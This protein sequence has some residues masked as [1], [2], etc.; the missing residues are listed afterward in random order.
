MTL[1][2]RRARLAKQKGEFL[3]TSREPA[4]KAAAKKAKTLPAKQAA[5]AAAK[6]VAKPVADEVVQPAAKNAAKKAAKRGSGRAAKKG[7]AAPRLVP[8]RPTHKLR[9]R[10]LANRIK[11]KLLGDAHD[12]R[13]PQAQEVVLAATSVPGGGAVEQGRHGTSMVDAPVVDDRTFES[14][15]QGEVGR[16]WPSKLE[17][18]DRV[19][20]GSS[21]WLNNSCFGEPVQRHLDALDVR[22]DDRM[23][24][25]LSSKRGE[26]WIAARMD[27]MDK[28]LQAADRCWSV[29]SYRV[30]PSEEAL[31]LM[32]QIAPG[33]ALP[34][35][36]FT[37]APPAVRAVAL[38]EQGLC[39]C[40]M[41]EAHASARQ[42]H[43]ASSKFGLL[44][45]L[46][47]LGAARAGSKPWWYAGW[48]F[49][50]AS[51]AAMA[52][53]FAIF[54]P[55]GSPESNVGEDFDLI[56]A[57]SRVFFDHDDGTITP[58]VTDL[59]KIA[60]R[61]DLPAGQFIESLMEARRD[62]YSML[63]ALGISFEDVYAFAKPVQ[64]LG[65]KTIGQNMLWRGRPP[66]GWQS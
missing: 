27:L 17:A 12:P 30:L 39:N 7:E 4:A 3:S 22:C 33:G 28:C 41:Y 18:C 20:K 24:K 1:A 57:V 15:W 21:L 37:F 46:L 45:F 56:V 23:P 58:L 2:H 36:S 59:P 40:Y 16:I 34:A 64:V 13:I 5:K 65:A 61:L 9:L 6:Q 32:A 42:L 19:A 55:A 54:G 63:E 53:F 25:K 51:L 10:A 60:K 47:R 38:A 11:A 49:D 26:A 48:V 35:P 14:W 43:N 52:Q 62:Y 31:S 50:L 29:F 8:R 44:R 66:V